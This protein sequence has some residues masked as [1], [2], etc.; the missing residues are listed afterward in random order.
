MGP[1]RARRRVSVLRNERRMGPAVVEA[2]NLK[3]M[4]Q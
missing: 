4:K 1:A 2:R 3:R